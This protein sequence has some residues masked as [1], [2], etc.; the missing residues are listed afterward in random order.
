M[1]KSIQKLIAVASAGVM[2]L[3]L[4]VSIVPTTAS[5]VNLSKAAKEAA[6]ADFDPSG[7]TEYHAYFGLQQTETWIYRD[8]WYAEENGLTGTTLAEA[9]LKFDQGTLFQSLNN[10]VSGIEGTKVTDATITGNGVYTVKVENLNGVLTENASAVLAMIYVD[11]DIPM[12]AKDNP[13]TISDWKLKL[14]GNTQTL[15]AEV[16]FPSEYNDESGLLRFDPVNTYQK[17]Q[18]D[19]PDCPSI[20]APQNSIEITFTVSGMD[21][22]NPDAVE[23][24]P[25][26]VKTSSDS[27]TDSDSDSGSGIGTAGVVGIVVVVIVIV[28]IVVVVAK[29]KRD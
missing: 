27:N 24:T 19:Y 2:A 26:P 20:M 15:P 7:N 4:A 10:V 9:G 8:E 23:A 22:D 12:T 1:R 14:D 28:A 18:G 16:Y 17:D 5:A 21:V 11:T 29:K 3:A 25:E 13:V 6:K